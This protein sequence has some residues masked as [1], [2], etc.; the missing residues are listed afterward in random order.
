MLPRLFCLVGPA[1]DLSV[2]PG[3]A[4]LGIRGFQ[5]R[6]KHGSAPVPDRQALE[7][8]RR[9]VAAVRPHGAVV[10]VDD[11]VDLALAGAADGVHLGALDLPVAEARRIAPGLLLGATCRDRAEV[12]RAAEEG[13]DY[14]GLGPVFATS[15]KPGLPPALGLAAI[16][17]AAGPLPLLAIGG[18]DA[19]RARLAR[20]AGAHGVAVIGAL[21]R[22]PDP[23]QAARELLDA[24]A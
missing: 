8:V 20:E 11:R 9:V 10:V 15:S 2:L 7:L 21:W 14:A 5:V 17:A 22:P 16:T 24:V 1:D 23:L 12:R 13:A 4:R 6:A 18:L 3:L 19:P